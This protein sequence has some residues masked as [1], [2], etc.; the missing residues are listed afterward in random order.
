MGA[1]LLDRERHQLQQGEREVVRADRR[2]A[3]QAHPQGPGVHARRRLRHGQGRSAVPDPDLR[4]PDV[5]LLATSRLHQ[6][7]LA[8]SRA[9]FA[10]AAETSVCPA[11]CTVGKAN[12]MPFSA[13]TF[14]IIA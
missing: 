7:L 1:G 13:N 14:W 3:H 6:A 11:T 4:P 2:H 8:M 5:L 12:W 10:T 9:C